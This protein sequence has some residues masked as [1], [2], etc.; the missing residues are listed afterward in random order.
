MA[1]GDTDMNCRVEI[2]IR[3]LEVPLKWS[4]L[5]PRLSAAE[6]LAVHG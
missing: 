3:N 2:A 4:R 1:G 6:A 5:G